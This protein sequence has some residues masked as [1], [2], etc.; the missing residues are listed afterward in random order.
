MWSG[1]LVRVQSMSHEARGLGPQ[2]QWVNCIEGEFEKV[3]E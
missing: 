1:V 2:V 3:V